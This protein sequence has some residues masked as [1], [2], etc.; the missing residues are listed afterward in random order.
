EVMG[1]ARAGQSLIHYHA[2]AAAEQDYQSDR[3]YPPFFSAM[4]V[5][6]GWFD[7]LSGVERVNTQTTWPGSGMSPAQIALTDSGRAFG[8]NQEKLNILPRASQQS[9][10]LNPWTLMADWAAAKD[11][12][13]AGHELYRDY[14]RIV[15]TRTTIAGEQRLLL[16]SKTGFPLKVE[17]NE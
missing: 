13:F 9:R 14:S 16:D 1:F 8:I 2:L 7:P 11:V 4:Q 10:Y 3:T 17:L 15:L 5:K 6:E 12:R